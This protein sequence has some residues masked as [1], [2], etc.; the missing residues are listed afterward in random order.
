MESLLLKFVAGL[1]AAAWSWLRSLVQLPPLL[2][3]DRG[4]SH[5]GRSLL[6]GRTPAASVFM[7]SA[8]CT[9]EELAGSPLR[10]ASTRRSPTTARAAAGEDQLARRRTT[11]TR[12]A[13]DRSSLPRASMPNQL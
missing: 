7:I 12:G 5:L 3:P 11:T 4:G 2:G 9:G 13:R 6:G 8:N 10:G 1:V